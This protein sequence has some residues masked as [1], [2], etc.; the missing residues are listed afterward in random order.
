M[1][2]LT[3]LV[4][5]ATFYKSDGSG[6]VTKFQQAHDLLEDL[7]DS[8]VFST[9]TQT[10]TYKQQSSTTLILDC[11][12]SIWPWASLCWSGI[13]DHWHNGGTNRDGGST[14][15]TLSLR[16]DNV[17]GVCGYENESVATP[18]HH[19]TCSD[20]SPHHCNSHLRRIRNLQA[21]LTL[22]STSTS[23]GQY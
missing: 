8:K 12:L 16:G 4:S 2:I 17:L 13:H 10:Q 5:G 3:Q 15:Q 14:I 9:K 11:T 7:L 22:S 19:S 18:S 21:P 6:V 20:R 1:A 23:S